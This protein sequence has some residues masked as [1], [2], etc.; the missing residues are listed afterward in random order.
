MQILNALPNQGNPAAGMLA[1]VRRRRGII[2]EVKDF[3]SGKQGRLHLVTVEYKD[4][5]RP[6]V[7]EILWELEPNKRL[8]E[9]NEIPQSVNEPMPSDDFDALLRAARWSALSPYIRSNGDDNNKSLPIC[10]PFHGALE[11]D[12]YQLIPLLKALRMPRISLMIADDVGIGK[13]IEA[14]LILN[15]LL[16]RRK[17]NRVLILTPASL[18]IQWRDEMWDKFSLSFD[19]IDRDSTLK[20]KRS[21]GIDANPWR[22]CSRIIASYHYLKQPDVF[23]QFMSVSRKSE[24][25]PRLPW[26]LLIVD[27][28]HNLM[29]APF[30]DDSQLCKT[31]RYIA[32]LFENRIFL[33]ATPH[34][35]HTRSF[36]GLLELLDPVRFSRTDELKPAEK[37]RIQQV[38][39]RRLKKEI[40]KR[41]NPPCFCTRNQP[42]ALLLD[43]YFSQNELK[44]IHAFDSFRDKVRELFKGS[45][46][47]RRLAGSFAIEIL[48][49]RLLSG[50]MTFLE[51]WRRCKHGLEESEIADDTDMASAQNSTKQDIAD[52]MEAQQNEATAATVI[53]SWMKS[54]SADIKEEIEAIDSASIAFGV[55]IGQEIIDQIPKHDARFDALCHIIENLCRKNDDWNDNERLVI[56]T[57]YKTT[58]D[59]LLHRLRNQYENEEDRFLS[60]YG[61]MNDN[62][63][64]EIKLAFNDPDSK[65]RILVAT[66][67]AAEGLNLQRTAR[68][69]LHYDCPWNPSK[70]EQRNG[71]LDRHGQ[72]RDVTIFHFASEQ[73]DDLKFLHYLIGKVDQIREDLGAVGDLFDEA[74]HRQ[75]IRGDSF[76]D[77]QTDLELQIDKI[78]GE[79]S[80]SPDSTVGHEADKITLDPI[81]EL[82]K[83]A[84]DIDLDPASARETLEAAMSVDSGR[85]Q[86]TS[87]DD[88]DRFDVI[89]PG[90]PGWRDIIDET[91]RKQT[92]HRRLGPVP[93]L[94][95]SPKAF[96]QPVGLRKVFRPRIDTLMLHLGHPIV[97]KAKGVLTRRR[98]PG[99]ASVSRYTIRY[100]NI[101]E[102]AYAII[103]LHLEELGINELR[104]TF[105]HWINTFQIPVYGND[106]GAPLPLVT[107][108][109]LRKAVECN[110]PKDIEKAKEILDEFEDELKQ[111]VKSRKMVLTDKLREKLSVDGKIAHKETEMRY[112]SRQGEVSS[113]IAENT[114]AKLEREILILKQERQQG[115]L[116][117]ADSHMDRL[118]R[119]IQMKAEELERRKYH[120]EEIRKQLNNERDRILKNLLPKRYKLRGEAQVFP[121]AVEIRLPMN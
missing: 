117:D 21:I 94:T 110:N 93:K 120:Y 118:D 64:E 87:E 82:D 92:F 18:R 15:E 88:L 62:D 97:Q 12:D 31:L 84:K 89:N 1:I 43:K 61:G 27:E 32:P 108:F 22:Y 39:I 67:A 23:E 78:K 36:T 74:S 6:N 68:L 112:Q 42:H 49:K 107:P 37:E 109:D 100:A 20:I 51:S 24:G 48:G 90:L 69:L 13:T 55:K 56:F 116:F 50:P 65:V 71:R 111:F 73:A 101:P 44:L 40:N 79:S 3:D 76:T 10:S 114:M 91:I 81:T 9:P 16:I 121:V 70:L 54:F 99:P 4:D 11:V 7:E 47:K 33:T 103:L 83:L 119:S 26:D 60:L 29:P 14:G 115:L 45:S 35:G 80:I 5:T 58:L 52:D 86:L 2:S 113:L 59:Y 53:G 38:V 17:I 63:R 77:V 41:T 95:F 19:V 98:F 8:L 34:N 72:A 75:L 102:K 96:L 105:H 57:E 104:E 28:V 85:P 106:L 46:K 25:S 30:G 66:D